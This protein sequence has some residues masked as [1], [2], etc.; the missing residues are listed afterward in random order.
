[1]ILD[2]R[3]LHRVAGRWPVAGRRPLTTSEPLARCTS[4]AG[5]PGLAGTTHRSACLR[6]AVRPTALLITCALAAAAAG[7]AS[8]RLTAAPQAGV[9][10]S[11]N[12][13]LDVNLSD[14]SSALDEE[15][16]PAQ[17][18]SASDHTPAPF[19]K[20]GTNGPDNP[21][22]AGTTNVLLH[23]GDPAPKTH[24]TTVDASTVVSSPQSITIT[25]HG[26]EVRIHATGADGR[27]EE[28]TFTA[29]TTQTIAW[30]RGGAEA[31]SGWN[32]PV[33]I[34]TTHP[35]KGRSREDDY[36]LDD[37]GHL[38]LTIQTGKIDVKLVYDRAQT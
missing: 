7:C 1:M 29:G 3:I 8:S 20:P 37:A 5:S 14:D 21:L 26:S 25:Q 27:Q 38:I 24:T 2:A 36:A 31:R 4:L 18:A 10:L 33:F 22:A 32:G 17:A 34:V 11:G 35:K 13:V 9:N 6:S 16:G 19:T 12:W 30:P 15:S 23:E 28:R